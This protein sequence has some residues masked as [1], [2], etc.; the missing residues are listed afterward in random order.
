MLSSATLNCLI[1]WIQAVRIVRIVIMIIVMIRIIVKII[2]ISW[3]KYF[4]FQSFQIGWIKLFWISTSA[5]IT[6]PDLRGIIWRSRKKVDRI[7]TWINKNISSTKV[8]EREL[9]TLLKWHDHFGVTI[10][11]WLIWRYYFS[12]TTLIW[13]G[14]FWPDWP[15]K[16]LPVD[17]SECHVYMVYILSMEQNE[18]WPSPYWLVG[19][20]WGD[21]CLNSQQI[22]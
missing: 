18:M 17:W 22:V 20:I 7:L 11:V 9:E 5:G 8:C 3:G 6:K 12:M 1:V 10:L 19:A 14:L 15:T 13:S 4:V 16:S 21:F 2:M